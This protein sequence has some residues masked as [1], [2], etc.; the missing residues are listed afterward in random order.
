[1][2]GFLNPFLL[3]GAALFAVPLIIHLLNRRRYQKIPWAAMSFLLGAHKRNRRRV[4]MENLLLL[5]ARC[6]AVILLAL[7][8]ARPYLFGATP[9]FPTGEKRKDA[10]LVLD[11][12]YS[13]GFQD[14]GETPF[15]RGIQ[16]ALEIL[17][18]LN[19]ER[20][21]RA[22]LI[23]SNANPSIASWRD[24]S[25]AKEILRTL[26]WPSFEGS[27]FS[28]TLDWVRRA[29]ENFEEGGEI[30]LYWIS[31]LQKNSF[32]V[33]E[34][35]SEE[36]T[37]FESLLSSLADRGV[38]L[39]VVDVGPLAMA[40]ANLGIVSL[41]LD[42]W[43]PNFAGSPIFIRA[44]IR[45]FGVLAQ[46]GVRVRFSIDG[47]HLT[48]ETADIPPGEKREVSVSTSISQPG[49]HWITSSLQGDGLEP[50]DKRFHAIWVRPQTKVLLVDGDPSPDPFLS[51]TG[52]LLAILQPEELPELSGQKFPFIPTVID[53]PRFFA[54][55]EIMNEHDLLV[56]ANVEGF[57][58][59]SLSK[60]H[61]YVSGGKA[62]LITLGDRIDPEYYNAKLHQKDGKDLLPAKLLSRRAVSSRRM[63]YY[64]IAYPDLDHPAFLFF[65]DEKW[66]PLLTEVP[67]YE[68]FQAIPDP[69]RSGTKVLASL[70]DPERSPLLI[71]KSL[72]R[73]K[74]M[75]LTTTIDL[76]WNKIPESPKTFLPLIFELFRYLTAEQVRERDLSIGEPIHLETHRFPHRAFWTDALGAKKKFGGAPRALGSDRYAL[77]EITETSRPGI[78]SVEVEIAVG[79]SGV[80][81]E[82]TRFA[83]NVEPEEGNLE[84][85][86]KEA[87]PSFFPGLQSK[88][89]DGG[90][91]INPKSMSVTGGGGEIWKTVM[92][93][94]IGLL[95]LESAMAAWFGRRRTERGRP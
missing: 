81:M 85:I 34:S 77:P 16:K 52:S 57:P 54:N 9:V 32:L 23:L 71:E 35:G 4:R 58:E 8:I 5:L 50:D 92:A 18:Q 65:R 55:P 33:K 66:K 75:L 48:T 11:R 39:R 28:T 59:G 79:T 22:T 17:D 68:F 10:I 6:L 64:R 19:T 15:Q 38:K 56:L 80:T 42:E 88:P 76:A 7:A 27:N 78:Y 31:D 49:S 47:N 60:L 93:M 41:S 37:W 26:D 13:M 82:T 24:P 83:V 29:A 43:E 51:E 61:T 89:F 30:T 45:N 67:V 73:G 94:G 46:N 21:D 70:D 72:G 36:K 91:S 20:G 2:G 84:Q 63:E 12:S 3:W 44:G 62:L 95:V 87:V 69:P 25:K 53:R 86:P 74:V 1:M 40:P 14:S 90:E